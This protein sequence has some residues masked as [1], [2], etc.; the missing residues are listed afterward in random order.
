MW[1]DDDVDNQF[2]GGREEFWLI[3]MPNRPGWEVSLEVGPPHVVGLEL[4]LDCSDMFEC[5]LSSN[6]AAPNSRCVCSSW[7][8]W[9]LAVV[10]L[11]LRGVQ[12]GREMLLDGGAI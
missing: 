11:L 5:L 12:Q 3:L 4:E 6:L 2:T 7:A 10:A 1:L 8:H 9:A